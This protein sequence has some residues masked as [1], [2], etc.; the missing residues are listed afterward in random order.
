MAGNK[1]QLS[2][3]NITGVSGAQHGRQKN[4]ASLQRAGAGLANSGFEFG[5]ELGATGAAGATSASLT[6]ASA[7]NARQKNA[8]AMQRAGKAGK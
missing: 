6:G 3:N 1:A 8:K 7:G 4:A 2:G 5:T